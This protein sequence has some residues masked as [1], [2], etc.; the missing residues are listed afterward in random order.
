MNHN[1]LCFPRKSTPPP[2]TAG[3]YS[4]I[5]LKLDVQDSED[6]L[7]QYHKDKVKNP[8]DPSA[9]ED[10]DNTRNDLTFLNSGDD[11]THPGS[12]RY[13]CENQTHKGT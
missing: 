11:T 2:K 7:V 6:G 1:I 10:A 4:P 8:K 3:A 12:N 9:Q 5:R 13:D